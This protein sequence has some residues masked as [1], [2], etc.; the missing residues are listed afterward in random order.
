MLEFPK[1]FDEQLQFLQCPNC[2]KSVKKKNIIAEGLRVSMVDDKNTAF[3]VEYKCPNCDITT[4]LELGDMSL[5]DFAL[6]ILDR[7]TCDINDDDD[8]TMAP[9]TKA[10]RSKITRK[11]VDIAKE[12]IEKSPD[13]YDFMMNIGLTPEKIEEY[14]KENK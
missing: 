7:S 10:V 5:E 3:F 9:V 11:E 2:K 1:W 8:E 13:H 4:T 12:M 14:N 6:E